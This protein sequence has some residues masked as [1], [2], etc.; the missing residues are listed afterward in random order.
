[1]ADTP[2]TTTLAD[3]QQRL[4]ET[5]RRKA[6]LELINRMLTRLTD[7]SG[8]EDMIRHILNTLME[9]IGAANIAL[10]HL[11]GDQFIYNDIYGTHRLVETLE[12][13]KLLQAMESLTPLRI[14]TTT[15]QGLPTGPTGLGAT[16]TWVFPLLARGRLIGIL[17]MEDMQLLD[18]QIMQEIQP[19]FT[20]A[21]LMLDNEI[22]NYAQLAEAHKLL[23]DSETLYRS[24]FEQSA[25]GIQLTDPLTTKPVYFNTAA[26]QQLGYSREEFAGLTVA[27]YEII[28]SPEAIGQRIA[29]LLQSGA[30]TFESVY[31]TKQGTHINTFVTLQTINVFDRNLIL[32]SI[33]N[34]TERKA[35]ETKQLEMERHLLHAQKLESL[36]VLA[37]GIA[38]DF[39]N[40]LAAIMGNL[41]LSLLQLPVETPERAL[42]ERAFKACHRAADLTRQMLAYSGKGAF[43]LREVDLGDLVRTN[44]EL[45][46]TSIPRTISMLVETAGEVPP[47]KADPGQIQQVVMNLITNAAESM[48]QNPGLIAIN[49]G[50]D[51]YDSAALDQSHLEEKPAAG[52]FVWLEV[53]D[54]GCGMD[55]QTRQR[56]FEPFFTTK[57]TGRGL[58]M[59]A[60]QGIV[61]S[62]HGAIFLESTVGS[63]TRFRVLFP[64]VIHQQSA[65][66]ERPAETA[67][68]GHG[69]VLVA[70]DEDMVRDFCAIC[71]EQLG[72]KVLPAADGREA[73][74]LF[75]AHEEEI[76]LAILDLTMPQMDGVATFHELRRLRPGLKVIISSGYGEQNIAEQFPT[77]KPHAFIQKPFAVKILQEL[78]GEIIG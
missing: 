48:G 21:S 49:T 55:E 8:L 30:T 16:E 61:R 24:L 67:I 60:V 5:S 14:P 33:R 47:I 53:C 46:R 54:N 22:T 52:R 12:D 58:G 63:G 4:T 43:E 59:A 11:I 42:I 40:L 56:L 75:L 10:Y 27:D 57:F 50:V 18:E 72:Y 39:N 32:A 41:D 51:D 70:D 74:E 62:H 34:I 6:H 13:E 17:V 71:I 78:I 66:T 1:M 19:F 38:H 25:D 68:L 69:L 23:Q 3:L 31:R 73:L 28:D 36:G 2:P 9:T 37:G 45:L 44:A 29:T 20:Y 15:N 7:V 76:V 65:T 64:A 77:E 35:L 26:H